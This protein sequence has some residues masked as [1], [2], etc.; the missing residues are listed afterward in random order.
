M[1]RRPS[2]GIPS[3]HPQLPPQLQALNEFP[4]PAARCRH[5]E[6]RAA[7]APSRRSGASS[8]ASQGANR[9]QG[10]SRSGAGRGQVPHTAG[11]RGDLTALANAAAAASGSAAPVTSQAAPTRATTRRH[12]ASSARR[13]SADV[14]EFR[15]TL[16]TAGRWR[17]PGGAN[18]AGCGRLHRRRLPGRRSRTGRRE[19]RGAAAAAGAF[20]QSGRS[21]GRRLQSRRQPVG[22]AARSV[23]DAPADVLDGEVGDAELQRLADLPVGVCQEAAGLAAGGATCW[24]AGAAT[25]GSTEA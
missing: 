12:P 9:R 18:A 10:A 4:E 24:R 23:A 3:P 2:R 1:I 17:R 25:N 19:A 16:Q 14:G 6:A 5:Q 15:A 7:P 11:R 8:A 22:Q 20:A 21:G 13:S